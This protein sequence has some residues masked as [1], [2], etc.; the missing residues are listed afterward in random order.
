MNFSG[1][2]NQGL[3][4][5]PPLAFVRFCFCMQ[6]NV[7]EVFLGIK[8]RGQC[9]VKCSCMRSLL[10]CRGGGQDWDYGDAPAAFLCVRTWS[11]TLMCLIRL[12]TWGFVEVDVWLGHRTTPAPLQ[13]WGRGVGGYT[14]ESCQRSKAV[15]WFSQGLSITCAPLWLW[16]TSFLFQYTF[17]NTSIWQKTK[18]HKNLSWIHDLDF[19]RCF[20]RSNLFFPFSF[21]FCAALTENTRVVYGVKAT[22][23]P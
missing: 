5:R 22:Q 4:E 18:Q 19:I 21:S 20:I 14:L 10:Q 1:R 2:K 11:I 13:S 6:A 16:L 8:R 23:T 9:S 17:G 12:N 15:I 3:H 7:L